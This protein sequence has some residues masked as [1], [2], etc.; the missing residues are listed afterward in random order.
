M[1]EV[2]A[3]RARVAHLEQEK[4]SLAEKLGLTFKERYD[5]LVRHLFSTCIQL[6]VGNKIL[7][8]FLRLLPLLYSSMHQRSNIRPPC[9]VCT[10]GQARRVPPTDG[11][12]CEREGEQSQRRRRGQNYKTQ[13]DVRLHQRQRRTH[14]HTSKGT[15]RQT[16]QEFGLTIKPPCVH[17]DKHQFV[18]RVILERRSP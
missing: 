17:F 11:A 8:Q 3:L 5:P 7:Y 16:E 15:V 6:K 4:S 18:L 10:S 13:E 2:S 1:L 14:P 9:N 12:G